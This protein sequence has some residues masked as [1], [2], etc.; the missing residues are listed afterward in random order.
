MSETWQKT[1]HQLMKDFKFKNFEEAMV[2]INVVA[3]IAEASNHHPDI[4]LHGYN[5]VRLTLSTHSEGK[6]TDKD[7][8]LAGKIDKIE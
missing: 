5:K 1:D 7:F 6:V 3:K 4:F 8:E 2:F